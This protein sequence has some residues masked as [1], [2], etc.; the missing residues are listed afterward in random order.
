MKYFMGAYASSP[1]VGD[2]DP[3]LET[4]YY[5]EIKSFD[6]VMGLEHPFAGSL[7]NKDEDWFLANIDP[8]WEFVFTCIPGVMGAIGKNP[9]FGIASDDDAGRQEAL[10]FILKAR[11]A[12]AKLNAQSG[13]EV[14]RAIQ[15]HT[16]PNKS[17]AGSSKE[18]LTASLTE[19][20]SWDWQGTELVIEH[21]DAFIEGQAPSKGFLSIEDEIAA[22]T[23]AKAATGKSVGICINWGRSAIE[24]RSA[25]G[26]VTHI[27]AA[28]NAGVLSG[29]MFSGASGNESD[30]GVWR[31]SHMPPQ[32]FT[33][34]GAGEPS[35]LMTA[36]T[37]K[38]CLEAAGPDSLL[39][40]GA[41]LGIR[42]RDAGVVERLSYNRAIFSALDGFVA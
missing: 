7:H 1:N 16:S 40:L 25:E 39:Y 12:I 10:A 13:K 15:I 23:A 29:L 20:L 41:K 17:K 6:N 19:M 31:D 33:T 26:V 21:C 42:P 34:G 14:V 18:S 9:N 28:K 37:I 8:N 2:W 38:D 22:I 27:K 5:N 3:A 11:D 36:D 32:A 4:R 30:Y 24:T 35:S